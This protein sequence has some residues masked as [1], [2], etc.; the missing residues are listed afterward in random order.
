M[1]PLTDAQRYLLRL[2]WSWTK[3]RGIPP[4]TRELN[5]YLGHCATSGVKDTLY[6]LVRKGMLHRPKAR[7]RCTTLTPAGLLIAE[8]YE[9]IQ[10]PGPTLPRRR[11]KVEPVQQ[12]GRCGAS[13]FKWPC[14]VCGSKEGAK[15]ENRKPRNAELGA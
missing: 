6:V 2:F 12:C 5:A 3:Q 15:C 13:T 10:L 9:Q 14:P 11:V 7:A 1:A 8:Q 4:T